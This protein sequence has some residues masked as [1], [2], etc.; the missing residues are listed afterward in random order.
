MPGMV[1]KAYLINPSEASGQKNIIVPL[2][3]IQVDFSGKQFVWLKDDQNKAVYREIT[4]G[5]LIGNGVVIEEGLQDG[6]NLI[7][8][9]YQNVSPGVTVE[10]AK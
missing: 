6:D 1:C 2:K 3:A 9:G 10:I 8:E 7:I 4:Q 5:K